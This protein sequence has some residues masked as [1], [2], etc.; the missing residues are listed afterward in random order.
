LTNLVIDRLFANLHD[1]HRWETF[2]EKM[3]LLDYWH[4]KKVRQSAA[5]S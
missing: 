4:A 2:L 1:D 3:N 5:S